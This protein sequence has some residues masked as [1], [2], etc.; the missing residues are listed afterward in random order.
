MKIFFIEGTGEI[1]NQIC[2]KMPHG[3][4]EIESVIVDARE[5]R[6]QA[7][8]AC[9]E[10]SIA[11]QYD[12]TVV[13]SKKEIINRTSE[14][15]LKSNLKSASDLNCKILIISTQQIT[16]LLPISDQFF[17]IDFFEGSDFFAIHE[18]IY[19]DVL[20]EL[21]GTGT[22]ISEILS[23]VTSNKLLL[24]PMIKVDNERAEKLELRK[25]MARM[26]EKR[27]FFRY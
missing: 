27:K 1:S 6:I 16:T 7:L 19:E 23:S 14:T 15:W 2:I 9:I 13:C 20:N 3:S 25:R 12:Y 18:S 21:R 22:T 11:S 26:V 8:T 10:E 24:Y 17:W 4:I 5:I